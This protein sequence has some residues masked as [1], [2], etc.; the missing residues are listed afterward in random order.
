MLSKR[1]EGA[2]RVIGKSQGYHGLAIRDETINCTVN[3]DGT[4]CMTTAWEP[5]PDELA[6]LNA[7]APILLTILGTGHPPVSMAV[8][9]AP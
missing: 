5:T 9:D 8:G 1:I 6:R 3:G 7:G 2:T 4:P